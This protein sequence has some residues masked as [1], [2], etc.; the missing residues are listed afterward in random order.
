MPPTPIITRQPRLSNTTLARAR[1]YLD[2]DDE[3]DYEASPRQ[4]APSI[5][6]PSGNAPSIDFNE[7]DSSI[8]DGPTFNVDIDDG[9]LFNSETPMEIRN[10]RLPENKDMELVKMF[11]NQLVDVFLL[12]NEQLEQLV[13]C[14]K[15]IAKDQ[16]KKRKVKLADVTCFKGDAKDINRFVCQIDHYFRFGNFDDTPGARSAYALSRMEGPI[17][18][19]FSDQ[20]QDPDHSLF[21]NS[22]NLAKILKERCGGE[23]LKASAVR[24]LENLKQGKKSVLEYVNDFNDCLADIEDYGVSAAMRAFELG[25][26]PDIFQLVHAKWTNIQDL[27]Q[28]QH[29][30]MD[31]QN[32]LLN[33]PS[34]I[35]SFG[36]RAFVAENAAEK[37]VKRPNLTVDTSRNP[38]PKA[39]SDLK[40]SFCLKTGHTSDKCWAKKKSGAMTEKVF[41][42]QNTDDSSYLSCF[43]KS[44]NRFN[45]LAIIELGDLKVE[46]TVLFDSG[47]DG[48]YMSLTAAR[49]FKIPT[50]K[51]FNAPKV[52]SANKAFDEKFAEVT[53]H[54]KLTF[55]SSHSETINFRLL[56]YHT[57][58]LILGS[59]WF[60]KH[61]VQWD[62]EC[63]K[64]IFGCSCCKAVKRVHFSDPVATDRPAKRLKVQENAQSSDIDQQLVYPKKSIDVNVAWDLGDL[65][66]EWSKDQYDRLQDDLVFE[67]EVLTLLDKCD[68]NLGIES[69]NDGLQVLEISKGKDELPVLPPRISDFADVFCKKGADKLPPLRPQFDLSIELE[70][71]AKLPKSIL[72]KRTEVEQ[73]EVKEYIE[74]MLEKGFIRRSKSPLASPVLFVPKKDGKKRLCVDYR[75]LNSI[76]VKDR[77]PLPLI[78]SMTDT[79]RGA[80]KFSKIDLRGAYN[81]LR[82]NEGDEW[83]TA[84]LTRYGQYEYLVMPFGLCNAPGAFQR[85][86]NSIFLPYID[87]GIINLLDDILIYTYPGED[88]WQKVR[89]VLKLLRENGLYAKWEKCEFEVDELEFLGHVVSTKGVSMCKTKLD[90]VLTWPVPTKLK[91]LQAFLG[92]ANYYRRF[93]TNFSRICSQLTALLK[94]NSPWYWG[95]KQQKAFDTLKQLFTSAPILIYP[96]S[97]KKF[98]L[99]T[100][101]SDFAIGA[102]LSQPDSRNLLHPIA[103]YSRKMLPAE[104]NYD[105]YDKEL[106]AVIDALKHW[107][108]YLQD[109]VY[110]VEVWTDHRNLEYFLQTKTLTRR[111]AR[112]ALLISSYDIVII[113][114][115]GKS[116]SKADALS[117]RPDFQPMGG[118][119]DLNR[120]LLKTSHFK[121][122]QKADEKIFAVNDEISRLGVF[123]KEYYSKDKFA[124]DMI[125][126]IHSGKVADKSWTL[127]KG[128]LLYKGLVYVPNGACRV[129]I[130]QLRHDAKSGGHFGIRKTLEYITR[131]FWWPKLETFVKEYVSTCDVCQ[132]SK[133]ARHKPYGLLKPLPLAKRPWGAVTLDFVTDLPVAQGYDSIMV[134]VDRFTKMSHFIP[135]RK[136]CSAEDAASLYI[137]SVYRL[138]GLPDELLS[139]R[140]TQFTSKFWRRLFELLGVHQK[141]STA[142]HPQTDGQTERVNQVMEQYL[143]CYCDYKQLNWMDL[144]SIAE[145]AYNNS[146]HTSI[147]MT[148]FFANYGY[149]PK[150]DVLSSPKGLS[151]ELVP[152][153]ENMVK[154]LKALHESLV[155]SLKQAQ[156]DM[157]RFADVKRQDVQKYKIGDKVWLVRKNLKTKRPCDKLDYKR[158][159]PFS[160]VRVINDVAVELKL[161]PTMG[162]HNVFHVSLIEPHKQN[163]IEGRV[164]LPPPPVEV[165][166]GIEYEV[167]DLLDHRF[168]GKQIYYLVLW[169]GYGPD[170]RTW[171]SGNDLLNSKELVDDYILRNGLDLKELSRSG[172]RRKRG[173]RVRR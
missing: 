167:E 161:P 39:K 129:L 72:Y 5:K 24:R 16:Q 13:K 102:V 94:K 61:K 78:T 160:I 116:N 107:R 44:A 46:L 30:A 83:K 55:E 57:Y 65:D 52:V 112:W 77:Y 166:S 81:L 86:V 147:Q 9:P 165:E 23:Y 38:K 73:R 7:S 134:V 123:F 2:E 60:R 27:N 100:D 140:G 131:D 64:P 154:E 155:E 42:V 59:H 122:L 127:E 53:P 91:E 146:F 104:R 6:T 22:K 128:L 136:T 12:Q 139:D 15:E 126:E 19:W 115:S 106:L 87:S 172:A 101:A 70:S 163:T 113:Y 171:V 158:L 164:E 173:G 90:A 14:V 105:I 75:R 62:Y 20:L 96:D 110:P 50:T 58:D 10:M 26:N 68:F 41:V 103:F 144:L 97:Q 80:I 170:E 117:R 34:E 18:K 135:C 66:T 33:K 108:H 8:V 150:M 114:K 138:H 21:K 32:I 74:E 82:I 85:W 40:C 151:T 98:I 109:T 28:F 157:K 169:K 56:D 137:N 54:V 111:Q 29:A 142:F 17:V 141:L 130:I 125:A 133:I 148:P 63:N 152:A 156:S 153:A 45:G 162:V 11:M 51:I 124:L 48:D 121:H 92:L 95:E 143:R 67:D 25:L 35:Q 31:A 118:D 145:F 47:A 3:V 69:E 88:H 43:H 99:E 71:N 159:G 49:K 37:S 149:H 1:D 79:L 36:K 4:Y 76:T 93:I 84:F 132:R 120:A 168:K 119:Q 89:L